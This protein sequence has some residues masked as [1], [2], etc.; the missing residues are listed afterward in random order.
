M[1]THTTIFELTHLDLTDLLSTA[2]CGSTYLSTDYEN[3][4]S[5]NESKLA[6]SLLN[7]RTIYVIDKGS[8]GV[9][10]GKLSH[11]LNGDGDTV[12]RLRYTDIINGLERA[13][14]G[15]FNARED[16]K[17]DYSARMREFARRSFRALAEDDPAW[18]LIPAD[19]LMQIIL[20]NEVVYG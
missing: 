19:C 13:A 5:C 11:T 20:F 9:H 12:Y 16:L 7:G 17:G 15:T 18:D 4:P 14:N 2:F 3:N 8:Q 6:T 1:K 10:Y